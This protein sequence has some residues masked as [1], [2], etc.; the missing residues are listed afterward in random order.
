MRL[1]NFSWVPTLTI[2]VL[3][4]TILSFFLIDYS[5][6]TDIFN[7]SFVVATIIILFD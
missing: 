3:L 7:Q 5:G 1:K 2:L 4:P 6:S